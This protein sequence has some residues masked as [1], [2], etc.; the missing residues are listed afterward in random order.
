MWFWSEFGLRQSHASSWLHVQRRKRPSSE[1]GILLP[2]TSEVLAEMRFLFNDVCQLHNYVA[3]CRMAG[4]VS[5]SAWRG[6]GQPLYRYCVAPAHQS[7]SPCYQTSMLT[8]LGMWMGRRLVIVLLPFRL[9]VTSSSCLLRHCGVTQTRV[10]H[11][12]PP[13]SLA[14]S[15]SGVEGSSC[16]VYD[17]DSA[18]SVAL[19]A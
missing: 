3:E 2:R 7:W 16:I 10:V 19:R 17:S 9:G 4:I 6:W 15:P 11:L 5:T 13:P 12:S 8:S 14:T 1:F 18:R